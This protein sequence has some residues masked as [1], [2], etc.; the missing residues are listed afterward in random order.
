M[1]QQQQEAASAP[2]TTADAAATAAAAAPAPATAAAAAAGAAAATAAATA[3]PAG[4]HQ[5]SNSRLRYTTAV[6]F[7]AVGLYVE[8]AAWLADAGFNYTNISSTTIWRATS[9]WFRSWR[10][11][12]C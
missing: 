12:R 1:R 6:S 9:A 5:S 7:D 11:R 2:A 10:I 4:H 8:H 3:I